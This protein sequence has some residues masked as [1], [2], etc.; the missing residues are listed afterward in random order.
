MDCRSVL[1]APHRQPAHREL[2][3]RAAQRTA[4][5][6]WWLALLCL[7]A[8][9]SQSWACACGCG[10][11]DIGANTAFPNMADSGWSAWF[12]VNYMDQNKN[13]EGASSAP[14]AD[15]ADK[16]I[17]TWFYTVGGQYM[18]NH[19]WGV[20]VEVPIFSRDFTTTGDGGPYPVG[21]TPTTHL[22]AM[23]DMM[24][25]GV[26]AGFSPDMSTGVTFGIK[27]PTGDYT[28][29]FI[30]PNGLP[31]SDPNST[32]GGLAYDRDTLPG[33]GSTDLLI[34][35]YHVGGLSSDNRLAYF[36]QGRYQF[37]V[38]TRDGATGSYRPG[39]ELDAGVGLT[40]DLG[41]VGA[42]DKLAPVLQFLGS[43]R[44]SDGGTA[45]SL[46]S[47]Y[48]R[49]LVAPGFDTRVGKTRIFADAEF[50]V[51]QYVRTD[52]PASGNFGQLTASVIWKFQVAY[53]F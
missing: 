8:L 21:S 20:M 13:W 5:R 49:L 28:G 10:M 17:K 37:A 41:K 4:V 14:A 38:F 45:A 36:V 12:R 27:L 18:F 19:D 9:P 7:G 47:G 6:G 51:V 52:V 42:L 53:D 40:Y 22:T 2:P 34:G 26:Y 11:F 44:V 30:P 46:N 16:D 39:N 35:G 23:G 31:A 33:T 15:N 50:P 32:T 43:Y 3:P 25:Q 29:P 24:I 48:R 1:A